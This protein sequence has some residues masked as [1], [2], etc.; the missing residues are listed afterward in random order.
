MIC[1]TL[2]ILQ[3]LVVSADLV[4]EALVPYYRQILPTLNIFKAKNCEGFLYVYTC[5]HIVNTLVYVGCICAYLVMCAL[6]ILIFPTVNSGDG[7]DYSQQK[8]E[9][10]GDL[11]QETLE[12]FER[13]GGPDAFI[14]IKYMVPTYESC[15]Q[16]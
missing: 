4:G 7:I 14:N 6:L 11:I 10:I 2:K 3:H 16:V 1:T 15:L 8:R 13:H 9:N 12:A 5:M